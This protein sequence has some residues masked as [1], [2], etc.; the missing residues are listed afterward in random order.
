[1]PAEIRQQST[2]GFV[3]Q[4]MLRLKST[5]QNEIQHNFAE[6]LGPDWLKNWRAP[7]HDAGNKTF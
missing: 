6:L 7:Q 5:A 3:G 2:L 4:A 1:M